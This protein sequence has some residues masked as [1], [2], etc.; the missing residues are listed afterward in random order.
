MHEQAIS[1]FK[2]QLHL[3]AIEKQEEIT[4]NKQFIA[5]SSVNERVKKG[6]SWYPLEIKEE[7]YGLGE[8]P[9]LLV[10][11]TKNKGGKHRFRSGNPVELF[12]TKGDEQ[13]Q[14][15]I[16]YINEDQM[17]LIFHIEELPN[18]VGSSSLGINFSVSYTHL[19]L[20]TT[21]YV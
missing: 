1:H 5:T 15:V 12:N 2:H 19:T 18:W 6:F 3:L 8:F 7:G 20:P 9:F 4:M 21:P 13:L 11:R 16:H 14:A 10:E 17:K